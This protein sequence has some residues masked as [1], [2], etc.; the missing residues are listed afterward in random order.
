MASAL[1]SLWFLTGAPQA[2]RFAGNFCGPLPTRFFTT[3]ASVARSMPAPLAPDI[4]A[5][6]TNASWVAGFQ[7]WTTAS[8]EDSADDSRSLNLRNPEPHVTWGGEPPAVGRLK[9]RVCSWTHQSNPHTRA[10]SATNS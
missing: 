3:A 8:E 6:P 7:P 1:A 4:A 10:R 2:K 9:C 5:V